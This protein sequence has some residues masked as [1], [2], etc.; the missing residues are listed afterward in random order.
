M[1]TYSYKVL[2]EESRGEELFTMIW[3]AFQEHQ[4]GMMWYP[5]A[6]SG[7]E[8][9]SCLYA[10]KGNKKE[11]LPGPWRGL[12]DRSCDFLR[13]MQPPCRDLVRRVPEK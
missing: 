7:E 3:A 6:G 10:W 11:C 8:E 12:P 4:R 13:G 9:H 1:H 5:R 2:I